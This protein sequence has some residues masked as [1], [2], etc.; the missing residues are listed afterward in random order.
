MQEFD[1]HDVNIYVQLDNIE[2][3]RVIKTPGLGAPESAVPRPSPEETTKFKNEENEDIE[4]EDEDADNEARQEE[5]S[6]LFDILQD[7]TE[8]DLDENHPLDK[9]EWMGYRGFAGQGPRP[10][11][12]QVLPRQ[13]GKRRS[14]HKQSEDRGRLE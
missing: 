13:V 1:K 12:R 6:S 14:R 7:N 5:E 10:Q 8:D 3:E 9:Q 11:A 4:D 2:A